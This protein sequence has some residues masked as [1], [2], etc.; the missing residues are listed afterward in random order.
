MQ[1]AF[2]LNKKKKKKN[3]IRAL[4]ELLSLGDQWIQPRAVLQGAGRVQGWTLSLTTPAPLLL[5][6][7]SW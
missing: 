5:L 7:F 2:F 1:D 4:L 6:M 3:G